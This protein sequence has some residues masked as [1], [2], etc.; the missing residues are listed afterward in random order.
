MH[1]K[2][3][4]APLQTAT[5]TTT[6]TTCRVA[7]N[8]CHIFNAADTHSSTG[9]GTKSTL[10]TRTWHLWANTTSRAQTNMDGV[11]ANL[12]AT[13][14]AVLGSKHGCVGRRLVTVSFH[15]HT[16]SHTDDGFLASKIGDMHKGIVETSVNAVLVSL[17]TFSFVSLAREVDG[18]WESVKFAVIRLSLSPHDIRQLQYILRNAEYNLA[19]IDARA[20]RNFL[21]IGADLRRHLLDVSVRS[22]LK[23]DESH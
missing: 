16:A 12:L 11:D 20:E 22:S 7:W 8:R 3:A 4:E 18:I 2:R 21:I 10:A 19:I 13:S 6:L 23:G 5:T 14:G 17:C 15:L 1:C 9:E